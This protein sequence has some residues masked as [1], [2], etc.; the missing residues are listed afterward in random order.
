M[1]QI[2]RL[3]KGFTLVELLVVIAIIGILASMLIPSVLS[4][5]ER[6]RRAKCLSNL[7]EIGKGFQLY[8]GDFNDYYPSVREPGSTS[9]N[10][11]KSLGLLFDQYVSACKIFVCPSTGDKCDN[12]QPGQSF[13]PHGAAGS[14]TTENASRQCS[15]GYDD[16]RGVNTTSNIVIAADAPPATGSTTTGGK[17]GNSD[18]H[19]GQGQNVLLYGGDTVMWANSTTN[20]ML[21]TDNIYDAADKANPGI[22]D[23]YISQG[24]TSIGQ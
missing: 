22:S 20:P 23:S 15:Y 12:L 2:G 6:A 14:T 24:G 19:Q 7:R 13:A 11:M 8:S 4:V 10:P 17:A 3:K 21:G 18:N 1:A 5:R 16:T 9:T